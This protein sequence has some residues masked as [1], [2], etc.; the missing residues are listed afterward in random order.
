MWIAKPLAAL[1]SNELLA[2]SRASKTAPIA[3][4]LDW[5]RAIAAVGASP[6]LVFSPE[7]NVGGLV[8]SADRRSFECI[9]GPL[10]SWDSPSSAPRQLA[11]FAMAVSKLAPTFSSLTLRPRWNS[12]RAEQRLRGLPI[13]PSKTDHAATWVVP[14]APTHA[15][16]E[17]G[18]TRR[19]KRT[20]RHSL[21]ASAEIVWVPLE[22]TDAPEL[23]PFVEK[24]RVFSKAHQFS[25]P[26][27]PWFKALI[28]T[29]DA[30]RFFH[31]SART[32][33]RSTQLLI[34]S[35]GPRA[36]YLFGFDEASQTAESKISTA[37]LAHVRALEELRKL[38]VREYD[39]NGFAEGLEPGDA[40]FGVCEFKRGLGGAIE[41]YTQPVFEI[42]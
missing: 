17:S 2:W 25:A 15:K 4:T 6:Y 39:L 40:Y 1:T 28:G 9:N 38:G 14:V 41:R 16:Q 32:R 33:D 42:S 37:A 30:L 35:H 26:D 27:L 11:T 23:A 36:H 29:R 31:L 8:F 24:L 13:Q 20:L 5:G 7:E 34:A 12:E 18:F 3:Q 10:L 21:N 19:F 22:S